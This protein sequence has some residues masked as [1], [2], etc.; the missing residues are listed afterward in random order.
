MSCCDEHINCGEVVDAGC[1]TIDT[2][3]FP[4]WSD[5]HKKKCVTLHDIISELYKTVTDIRES[6]DI[7]DVGDVC[8][9]CIDYGV[10]E[11]S[12]LTVGRVLYALEQKVCN[13]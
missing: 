5:N 11:K 9:D 1:V 7:S 8:K 6:I 10:N 2:V 3:R 13:G 4:Q 12:E